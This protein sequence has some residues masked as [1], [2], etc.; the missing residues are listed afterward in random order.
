MANRVLSFLLNVIARDT[1]PEPPP[2]EHAAPGAFALFMD[3]DEQEVL[4]RK[5]WPYVG[6]PTDERTNSTHWR[7]EG[8]S[9]HPSRR[10]DNGDWIFRRFTGG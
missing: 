10:D 4:Y 3:E 2:V 9:F 5:A 6:A 1:T 8:Q 7:I